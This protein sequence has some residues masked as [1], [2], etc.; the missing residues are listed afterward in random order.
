[1]QKTFPTQFPSSNTA[2]RLAE[3]KRINGMRVE[4]GETQIETNHA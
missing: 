1:M 2:K 4:T 3:Q